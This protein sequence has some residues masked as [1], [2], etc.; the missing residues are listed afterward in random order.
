MRGEV[1]AT[2][3]ATQA[4]T[5]QGAPSGAQPYRTAQ[6]ALERAS[7]AARA[8]TK[9]FMHDFYDEHEFDRYLKFA[10]LEDE[11]EYHRREDE[12]KQAIQK[13]LD[14]QT[15]E[16]S[17]KALD[18]SIE[19]M[20]DAGAHGADRSPDYKPTLDNLEAHKQELER[21]IAQQQATPAEERSQK[22][23]TTSDA[24]SALRA[25]GVSLA[26][27]TDATKAAPRDPSTQ[28]IRT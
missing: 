2:V 12:R 23:P 19:Q 20:K 17:L 25:A 16:G 3:A 15:P 27:E 4:I 10:S 7:E 18:L 26:S 14:E 9:N 28:R 1:T 22:S 13:A 24:A 5:L 8:T 11:Q 21:R 6:V